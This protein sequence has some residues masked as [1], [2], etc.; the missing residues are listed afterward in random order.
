V[1]EKQTLGNCGNVRGDNTERDL[2]NRYEVV[3]WLC[4]VKGGDNGW[5]VVN[6]V[7]NL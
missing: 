4:V 7:M 2:K 3:D 1:A 5:A 6:T